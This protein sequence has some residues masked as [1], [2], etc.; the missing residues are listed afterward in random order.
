MKASQ[1]PLGRPLP[2]VVVLTLA[3][4]GTMTIAGSGLLLALDDLYKAQLR[5]S[6]TEDAERKADYLEQTFSRMLWNFA[7]EEL[8]AV[9]NSVIRD[10]SVLG[11]T[12]RTDAGAVAFH[13]L[14]TGEPLVTIQRTLVFQGTKVGDFT[15]LV[16][17]KTLTT[18]IGALTGASW[19]AFL[20]LLILLC[21]V[22]PVLLNRTV[23]LPFRRL[24]R[25]LVGDP[26]TGPF[27][28]LPAPSSRIRELRTFENALAALNRAVAQQM[29]ELEMRVEVRTRELKEAQEML[30]RT[31]TLAT[32]G[33]LAAGIAHELNTPLAAIL[34]SIRYLQIEFSEAL[35]PRLALSLPLS[36]P[37]TPLA[38]LTEMSRLAADL[39]NIPGANE[40]RDL[41]RR[42][43]SLGALPDTA[44]FDLVTT[45]GLSTRIEQL[46]QYATV[47]LLEETIR[48]VAQWSR[49]LAIIDLAAEKGAAVVSA[50]RGQVQSGPRA[51]ARPLELRREI[52]QA[53]A[54]LQNKIKHGIRVDLRSSGPV[55]VMGDPNDL[56]KV[57]LN[58]LLN[59][60]QS[61]DGEGTLSIS[62]TIQEKTAV[63][64][65]QDTGPGI[66]A[67]VLPR[68]FEPFFT[69]KPTGMGLGLEISRRIVEA[70]QG[71]ITAKS[72]PGKT[73][74]LVRLPWVEPPPP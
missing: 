15:F 25:A 19:L 66:P 53:L 4:V 28:N 65:V 14:K 70:H 42:W 26:G 9:G 21:I 20:G 27:P 58:L 39:E 74:F 29:D 13:Q 60:V 30:V 3:L 22:V 72:Q 32:L 36:G 33:Q 52:E 64:E 7:L 2:L 44:L 10:D 11:L 62:L 12:I 37:E 49:S 43:L 67:E 55:W 47:P 41:K 24:S 34:S 56:G 46:A 17:A 48:L 18:Q 71:S 16:S 50:L 59:A 8:Q 1:K 54:L 73:T 35:L 69:T 63:I 61:M 6:L 40:R 51:P 57:W 45:T 23:L 5:V 31:E 68:V 38:L